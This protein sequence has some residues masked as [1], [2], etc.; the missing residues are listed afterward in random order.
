MTGKLE[1]SQ[2][3]LRIVEDGTDGLVA[4]ASCILGD[5]IKLDS[6]AVRRSHNGSLY[7]SYP[8][9]RTAGGSTFHYHHPISREAADLVERAIMSRIRELSVQYR[10][11]QEGSVSER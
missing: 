6:I 2:V 10:P 5:A 7:L 3:S 1:V 9:K 4:W 8:G 11:G